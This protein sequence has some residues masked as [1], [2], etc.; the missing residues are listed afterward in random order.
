M[1]HLLEDLQPPLSIKHILQ[2]GSCCLSVRG[3]LQKGNS[4]GAGF[5]FFIKKGA[6]FFPRNL[7]NGFLV[8]SIMFIVSQVDLVR[9]LH[10]FEFVLNRN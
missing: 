8:E 2:E 3:V 7:Y 6:R 5:P 4:I 10:E 9:E 1:T